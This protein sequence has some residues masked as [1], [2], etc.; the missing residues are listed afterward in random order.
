MSTKNEQNS[1]AEEIDLFNLRAAISKAINNAIMNTF[2]FFKK[3]SYRLL[4]LFLKI[5]D[6]D[7]SQI[8]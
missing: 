2:L 3:I 4:F 7:R 8:M 6:H 1:N 5:T